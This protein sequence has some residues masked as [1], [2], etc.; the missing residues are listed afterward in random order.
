MGKSAPL[1]L[2]KRANGVP[3]VVDGCGGIGLCGKIPGDVISGLWP[4]DMNMG[5]D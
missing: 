2:D 4:G 3:G 5:L 1:P